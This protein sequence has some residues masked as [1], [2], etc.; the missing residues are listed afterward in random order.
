MIGRSHREVSIV[1]AYAVILVILGF[2]APGFFQVENWRSLAV[3][4]APGAVAAMGM[5]LV[6]LCRQIDISIGSQA[7]L[8]A[9][10]S[11]LLAKQ[12]WPM[13]L[14]A[15]ATITLGGMLGAIN[16]GLVAGLKLPSIVATLATL[17]IERESLRW[18]REGEFVRGLPGH[19]QWFGLGQSAGRWVILGVSAVVVVVVS[20]GLRFLAVGRAVY[21]SGSDA[22]AARLAG[23]RPD[24]VVFGAFVVM[25]SLAGLYALLIVIQ[26]PT[27]DPKIGSGLEL[28]TIAAVVIG[29]VAITGGRGSPVGALLGVVLLA[30]INPALIYLGTSASWGKAIEGGVILL[31][32]AS[33]GL[34]RKG[35]RAR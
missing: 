18:W 23:L 24:R 29:G 5:T 10:A 14:V 9:V 4:T 31:A 20:I 19:F 32:V 16:G 17:V 12:G 26:F 2:R 13:P 25:G 7:G 11:G 6:I 33:D 1:A 15:L 35:R 27:V 8:C 28:Q 30:T 22:E 3:A 21:A 34:T